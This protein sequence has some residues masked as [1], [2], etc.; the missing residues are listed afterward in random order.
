MSK[1]ISV[2]VKVST[3]ISS[4]EKALAEREQRYTNQEKEMAT[5]EKAKEAYNSAILKLVKSK[6]VITEANQNR[7]YSSSGRNSKSKTAEFQVT[8]ELP[9]TALPTEPQHP[10]AYSDHRY[11]RETTEIKQAIRVLKMTEQEYVNAS[12]LKSV[13]EYL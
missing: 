3:L 4:L 11:E 1:S 5:Y 10:E 7:W 13:S 6:G 8:M 2:K 9:K 12:T